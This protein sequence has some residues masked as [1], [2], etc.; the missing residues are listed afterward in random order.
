[1]E[2]KLRWLIVLFL[3]GAA[4]AVLGIKLANPRKPE[5]VFCGR[6]VTQWLYSKDYQTNR[7]AVKLAVAALGDKSVPALRRMLRSGAKW[8]RVWFAKA[9]RWLYRMLPFGGYQFERKDRAMWAIGT[10]GDD[11]REATPD[12]LAIFQDTT[13]HWNQR[14]R[15]IGTLFAIE[16][17]P[18][19][20]M[21]V[22]DKLTNDPV[23]G[24]LAAQH[25]GVFRRAADYQRN[26]TWGTMTKTG[27]KA[28][29]ATQ[30]EFKPS[31]S[32]LNQSSLWGPTNARRTTLSRGTNAAL[33]P[34][35]NSRPLGTNGASGDN[36]NI[37]P[38]KR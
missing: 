15:A 5:P 19:L 2:E 20:V 30:R 29:V 1:M 23:V 8:E 28:P 26:H 34:L 25:A 35:G 16:A 36:D 18:S 9:P 31:S 22:L 24:R 38:P 10:L 13:E 21:P 7:A 32:F 37:P 33:A 27:S 12:L 14:S 4:V 11:G 17:K 6:T 3:C